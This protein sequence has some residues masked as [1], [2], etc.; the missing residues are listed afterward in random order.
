MTHAA[1][2][3]MMGRLRLPE[4][5]MQ[6]LYRLLEAPCALQQAEL[7]DHL[8]RAFSA[9]RTDTHFYI[10]GQH[11]QVRTQVCG[12]LRRC[13]IRL[14]LLTGAE[15]CR[16]RFSHHGILDSVAVASLATGILLETCV[17]FGMTPNLSLGKTE[18]LLAFRGRESRALRHKYFSSQ[19]G[20]Q[21]QVLHE[22][23][24]SHVAVVGSYVHV[25]GRVHHSG[26]TRAEARRRIGSANEAFQAHRRQLF[27]SES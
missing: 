18:V 4:T 10:D 25:G 22:H 27:F 12:P 15:H 14:P 5:A 13:G 8:R 21:L 23:G 26:E 17:E 16:E 9:V 6:E 1:I 24:T 20:Q 19:Q 7:P 3:A 11:D 2:A